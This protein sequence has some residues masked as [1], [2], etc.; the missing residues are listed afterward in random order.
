MATWRIFPRIAKFK[1]ANIKILATRA[2]R[3][4]IS[5]MT[6]SQIIARYLQPTLRKIFRIT[7]CTSDFTANSS[8]LRTG[9]LQLQ[10][11]GGYGQQQCFYVPRRQRSVPWCF[12]SSRV[13][14]NTMGT[15]QLYYDGLEHSFPLETSPLQQLASYCSIQ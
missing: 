12:S 5:A 11:W 8:L 14:C 1:S 9:H 10:S 13:H 15:K 6:K 7:P 3:C 2:V 4:G